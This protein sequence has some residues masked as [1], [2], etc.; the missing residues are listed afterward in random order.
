MMSENPRIV[1][2]SYTVKESVAAGRQLMK[3]LD[4]GEEFWTAD[5]QIQGGPASVEIVPGKPAKGKRWEK[6]IIP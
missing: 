6:K 1:D 5:E 3:N 4:T 2:I